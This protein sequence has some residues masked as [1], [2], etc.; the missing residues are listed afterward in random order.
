MWNFSNRAARCY[1]ARELSQHAID[2]LH[3]D[4]SVLSYLQRV[5]RTCTDDPDEALH[6]PRE[7]VQLHTRLILEFGLPGGTQVDG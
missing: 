6:E 2:S 5:S 3:T 7:L 4:I 1:Y